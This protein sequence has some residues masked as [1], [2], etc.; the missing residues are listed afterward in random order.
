MDTELEEGRARLRHLQKDS[1]NS[2][3][4][5]RRIGNLETKLA[6]IEEEKDSLR[7]TT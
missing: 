4:L 3:K 6:A 2:S 7:S 1:N 5:W